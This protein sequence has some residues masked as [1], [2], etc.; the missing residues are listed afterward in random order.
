MRKDKCNVSGTTFETGMEGKR[1]DCLQLNFEALM[2]FNPED[3]A[4][5]F[6]D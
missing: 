4:C 3:E 1:G 5:F 2:I 6:T